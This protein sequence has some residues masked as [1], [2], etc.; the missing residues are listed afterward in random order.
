[1]TPWDDPE[2]I[3]WRTLAAGNRQVITMPFSGSIWLFERPPGLIPVGPPILVPV[4]RRS[5]PCTL[6]KDA[7]VERD[8]VLTMNACGNA[9]KIRVPI[10]PEC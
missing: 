6:M 5:F 3:R 9:K 7:F 2:C 10:E 4:G 1:M 8:K